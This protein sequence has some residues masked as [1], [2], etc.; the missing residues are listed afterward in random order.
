MQRFLFVTALIL[1]AVQPTAWAQTEVPQEL[2][3]EY[4]ECMERYDLKGI[5]EL[6]WFHQNVERI[7]ATLY[8]LP[9]DDFDDSSL[10][11]IQERLDHRE[12]RAENRATQGG[13]MA[14]SGPHQYPHHLRHSLDHHYQVTGSRPDCAA[15]LGESNTGDGMLE[16]LD[17]GWASDLNLTE[18]LSGSRGEVNIAIDFANPNRIIA[19]SVAGGS[20]ET[21][22]FRA[23]S[24][25]WGQTWSTGQVGNNGGTTWE[26]DPVSYYQT[27][28]GRVYHGKLACT[29]GTCG[30]TYALLRY[31]E[32]NGVTW[33]DCANRPGYHSDEDREWITVDNTPSS[34]CYGTI[35]A[36]W[37]AT[38]SEKVARSTTNCATW[39][40]WRPLTS[41]YQAISPDI[42][43][44]ADGHVYVIWK[45]Y[46]EE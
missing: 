26:C 44:A 8:G 14:T 6:L 36:T 21:S 22:S 33:A 35:Y 37:H 2:L 12:A 5:Q 40:N 16:N 13:E 7:D 9:A 11:T 43:M 3:E 41:N 42:K 17:S 23:T 46:G 1:A 32:D 15:I 28:T 25:D 29:N 4:W 19:T 45:N 20:I 39:T 10:L 18:E 34:A 24:T 30:T 27:S 31:S 38:N